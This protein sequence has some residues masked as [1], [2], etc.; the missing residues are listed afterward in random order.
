M[1][2]TCVRKFDV[3]GIVE[4]FLGTKH[5]LGLLVSLSL[6]SFFCY[7]CPAAWLRNCCFM[8]FIRGLPIRPQLAWAPFSNVCTLVP[9]SFSFY[10]Q[11]PPGITATQAEE[12]KACFVWFLTDLLLCTNSHKVRAVSYN[13]QVSVCPT[14][15]CVCSH[16]GS[17]LES[18]TLHILLTH[19]N[20]ITKST[21]SCEASCSYIL[22]YICDF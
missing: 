10:F 7:H 5:P 2:H 14:N 21:P 16:E 6:F 13:K 18:I 8:T 9:F 3:M 4:I 11:F 12:T 19:K 15:D 20:K 1:L 22:L 17:K